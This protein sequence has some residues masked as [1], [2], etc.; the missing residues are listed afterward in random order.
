M[1][2][3]QKRARSPDPMDIL[4]AATDERAPRFD[5]PAPDERP[6]GALSLPGGA[7]NHTLTPEALR[8][9][10]E[11]LESCAARARGG[12]SADEVREIDKMRDNIISRLAPL[13]APAAQA[14]DRRRAEH[15]DTAA[16]AAVLRA[17]I[18]RRPRGRSAD[19][20]RR[21]RDARFRGRVAATTRPGR[22]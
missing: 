22:G 9:I 17:Q 15:L 20:S 13:A 11:T 10:E 14:R 7:R 21:R 4:A 3:Q 5:P 2:Q 19:E 12:A 1:A 8:L 18:A 6:V 16:K